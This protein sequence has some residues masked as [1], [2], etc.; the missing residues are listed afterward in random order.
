MT[1]LEQGL[2]SCSYLKEFVRGSFLQQHVACFYSSGFQA[3]KYF[4]DG[5][6][7]VVA[8]GDGLKLEDL[9]PKQLT[10][11]SN[12]KTVDSPNSPG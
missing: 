10:F 3:H 9:R 2:G 11:K 6:S 1:V 4:P 7:H 12:Y 5:N 8:G